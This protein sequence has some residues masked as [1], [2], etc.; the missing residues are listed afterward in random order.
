MKWNNIKQIINP[1]WSV[2]FWTID[3]GDWSGGVFKSFWFKSNAIKQAYNYSEYL[4][5]TLK[6]EATGKVIKLK[7]NPDNIKAPEYN[8]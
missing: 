5:I 8:K 6:N 7:N 1:T 4:F 2:R 3:A